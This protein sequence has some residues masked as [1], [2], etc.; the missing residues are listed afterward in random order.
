MAPVWPS[1]IAVISPIMATELARMTDEALVAE[2]KRV[3][4]LERR[5]TAELLALLIEVERRAAF[6]LGIVDV[7]FARARFFSEQAAY[8]RIT[9]ARAARRYPVIL[10]R[11]AEGALTLSSVGILAPHLTDENADA[12]L[13]AAR[14]KSTRDVERL[15]AAVYPQPDVPSSVR[16]VPAPAPAPAL[17]D[18]VPEN[19]SA[20]PVPVKPVP[21]TTAVARPVV[22]PIAPRRYLLKVTIDGATHEKLQRSRA[23]LRHAVPNGDIAEILDRALT[24]LLREAERAKWAASQRPRAAQTP[25]ARGRQRAAASQARSLVSRRCRMRRPSRMDAGGN[26]VPRVPPRRAAQQEEGPTRRT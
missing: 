3:A 26:H 20:Q 17:L 22:A 2:T 7:C 15:I 21:P 24:L 5:S 16:A 19:Q 12:L 4:A 18:S 10:E 9:A 6:G 8:S 11:L 1:E 23:L 14:L 25:S 13:D